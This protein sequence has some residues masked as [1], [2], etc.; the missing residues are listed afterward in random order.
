MYDQSKLLKILKSPD[1]K[2]FDSNGKCFPPSNPIY[3]KI[4]EKMKELDSNITPKHIYTVLNTNRRGIASSVLKK[5]GI[6]KTTKDFLDK[7]D[8]S[9]FFEEPCSKD[10]TKVFKLIISDKNWDRIKPVARRYNNRQY[11]KLKPGEW[12]HIFAA[13]IWEQSKIPCAFTFKNAVVFPNLNAKYFVL[14]N[15]TCKECKAILQ[16][17]MLKKPC[18]GQDAIFDCTLS[19]FNDKIIHI[20]KRQLKG[21][22]RQK[23]AGQLIDRKQHATIWRTEEANNK[24]MTFGDKGPPILYSS[25]VLRKAKQMELDNRLGI[26]DCDPI[27][28][29]QIFKY[30]ERLGSIHG[31]G[32]DPFYIMYW[33]KEQITLYKILNRSNNSYFTMD[34]TGSIAK[35]LSKP[36]GTKSAHLFLYQCVIVPKDKRGIPIF[37]MISTKQDAALLTYF[38]LEIRRAGATVPPVVIT[39]FSRA[40][41]V[42]L[43]RAFADCADLNHYL[44]RCYHVVME[45]NEAALPGSYLRLD[46]SHLI[47]IGSNWECLRKLPKKVRQFYLRCIAQAYKMQSMTELNSFLSSVLVVTLSENIGYV[48]DTSVPAETCLQLANNCIKGVHVED[49][50][51]TISI[52]QNHVMISRIPSILLYLGITIRKWESMHFII[53]QLQKR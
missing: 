17:K 36:D 29:L 25:N 33:S 20:K 27:R 32:L 11:L 2:C 53:L 48:D 26:V 43:A 38:L 8:E 35:K 42:A 31:I 10:G 39:D 5:F 37:Q 12:S 30:L 47:K 23:I 44:Q 22:L 50:D 41:L 15:A 18:D 6:I 1:Y 4:S 46:V 24:I 40:I 14:F 16:G 9:Y 51:T 34:A 45:N 3:I 28:N 13:K 49:V 7:S 52:P 19:G 21:S